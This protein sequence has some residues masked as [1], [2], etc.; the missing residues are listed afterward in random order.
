MNNLQHLQQQQDLSTLKFKIATY[1]GV[2]FER[3]GTEPYNIENMVKDIE[4]EF[5][6]LSE[7]DFRDAIRNGGLGKYGKT[8]KLTTQEVCVWIREYL[9]EKMPIKKLP[10]GILDHSNNKSFL[11]S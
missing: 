6:N 10:N 5:P 4:I 11:T 8:Y 3:T 1:I 9:K 7:E 2:A